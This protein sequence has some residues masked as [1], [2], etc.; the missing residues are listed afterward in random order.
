MSRMPAVHR[1]IIHQPGWYRHVQKTYGPNGACI[2]EEQQLT[3]T[4]KR[5][6]R[7]IVFLR[8]DG[9]WEVQTERNPRSN[10]RTKWI[11]RTFK[12]ALEE[13]EHIAAKVGGW[14]DKAP[15]ADI[16]R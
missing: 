8:I 4:A 10:H 9:E 14:R 15:K 7:L 13:A 2:K 6:V 5:G 11:G 12:A 3:R 16:L 1:R